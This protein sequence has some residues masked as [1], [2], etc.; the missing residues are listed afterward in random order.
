MKKNFF[1][2][3]LICLLFMTGC[4][5]SDKMINPNSNLQN[6]N[7]HSATFVNGM[8]CSDPNC[9]DSSHHHDCPSDC[10]DYSHHHN[11]DLDCQEESHHHNT[12]SKTSTSIHHQEQHHGSTH[13]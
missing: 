11:C 7:Y 10:Q 6:Q 5:R 1:V 12:T 2:I 4:G 13:H 3:T 9:T 8:G